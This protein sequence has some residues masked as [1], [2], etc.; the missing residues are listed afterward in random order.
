MG[1][2]LEE[3]R[4]NIYSNIDKIKFKGISYRKDIALKD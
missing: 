2:T 4:N 1:E 3:A